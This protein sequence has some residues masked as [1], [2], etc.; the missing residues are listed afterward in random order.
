[1]FRN[2]W[3]K[4]ITKLSFCLRLRE[5]RRHLLFL[6]DFIFLEPTKKLRSSTS[7]GHFCIWRIGSSWH[8]E[9]FV[10]GVKSKK[11]PNTHFSK[12][13]EKIK[14]KNTKNQNRLKWIDRLIQKL[15]S[16]ERLDIFKYFTIL[17]L[18][19]DIFNFSCVSIFK[20]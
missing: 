13:L 7:S 9:L 2:I 6:S 3:R 16:A 8:L 14:I 5:E 1:M 19:V 20:I 4:P 10:N 18:F 11:M 15:I 12:W 17:M